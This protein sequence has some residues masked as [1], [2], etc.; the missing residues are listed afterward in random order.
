MTVTGS[1]E[2]EPLFKTIP[3]ISN[4]I[5]YSPQSRD[6]EGRAALYSIDN[7]MFLQHHKSIAILPNIFCHKTLE[8]ALAPDETCAVV[9]NSGLALQHK[10]G[11]LIDGHDVVIR[12]NDAPTKG[13]EEHVGSK[14]SI[15]MANRH[16]FRALVPREADNYLEDEMKKQYSMWKRTAAFDWEEEV[17]L[18]W[19]WH[20]FTPEEQDFIE[21]NIKGK[22]FFIDKIRS[23]LKERLEAG[24]TVG[25]LSIYYAL[26]HYKRPI[27]CF[28]FSHF[29]GDGFKPGHYWETVNWPSGCTTHIHKSEQLIL[30]SWEKMG[31][32]KAH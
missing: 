26:Q 18:A 9:G 21:H 25:L 23:C 12:C 30:Q 16:L 1:G 11:S 14:S 15:R 2:R 29:C 17:V 7:D 8:A 3:G 20:E 22:L 32:I 5:F 28:G 19:Y 31:L 6:D 24:P 27:D 10:H 4:T 13:Y